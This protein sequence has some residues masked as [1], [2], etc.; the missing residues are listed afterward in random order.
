MIVDD[1]INRN[2]SLSVEGKFLKD[3]IIFKLPE[4][5]ISDADR[6]IIYNKYQKY[7]SVI[8]DEISKGIKYF[9]WDN[10]GEHCIF[11]DLAIPPY[12]NVIFYFSD[13]VGNKNLLWLLSWGD[14]GK[15]K[16][17]NKLLG[18]SLIPITFNKYNLLLPWVYCHPQ[19]INP[20][21]NDT[22]SVPS[23]LYPNPY[24]HY[25]I[26]FYQDTDSSGLPMGVHLSETY[27]KR[28]DGSMV[29]YDGHVRFIKLAL[30]FITLK[31]CALLNCRNIRTEKIVHNKQL[32]RARIKRGMLP[33]ISYYV[34]Q[35]KQTGQSKGSKKDLWTNRIHLCRGHFK[36]YTEENP[37]FGKYTGLWWWE[38]SVRGRNKRGVVVKNYQ[39]GPTEQAPDRPSDSQEKGK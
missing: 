24:E 23:E 27:L 35:I 10:N 36:K 6:K 17:G 39:L 19:V 29:M 11:Y 37:L 34:L 14:S 33:L 28:L 15:N 38:P 8:E 18:Y 16:K 20:D 30:V 22:I 4:N 26:D 13:E 32:Q 7:S 5:Y 3:A 12:N 1:F 31:T 9:E 21:T 2:Y 25:R